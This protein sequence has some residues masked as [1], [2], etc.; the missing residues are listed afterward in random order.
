MER[1]GLKTGSTVSIKRTDGRVHPAV[2][3]G[4][5]DAANT[6]TVEWFENDETKGKELDMKHILANNPDLAARGA[7]LA[8]QPAQQPQPAQPAGQPFAAP[9][10]EP[11]AQPPSQPVAPVISQ[12]QPSAQFAE[13]SAARGRPSVAQP[14]QP[15]SH[16]P[17]AQPTPQPKKL[18]P[19]EPAPPAAS[20]KPKP[21]AQTPTSSKG[22]PSLAVAPGPAQAAGAKKSTLAEVQK[23][24]K[25]R[26]ERR[27]QQQHN[28]VKRDQKGGKD[29]TNI[30]II[31]MIEDYREGVDIR[32]LDP[33]GPVKNQKIT[34][35]VR[36]R[37]LNRRERENFD[38][39]V[40]TIPDGELITVHEP[41]TKVDLTKY[42]D[43]HNFRFD[44]AFD[45]D[46][47]N[48]TVY[49][50]TASPLVHT[51]FQGGMATCFA[52]GQTGSGKTFTMGGDFSDVSSSGVPGIY[53]FA[54]ADVFRLNLLSDHKAKGLSVS[55]S[56]FE[57]YG[58]KVFDLLNK[59]QK[60]RILEDGNG[61]VQIV[62][63]S[64]VPVSSVAEVNE[65]VRLGS[66]ARAQGTTSANQ[67]SSRSHAVFQ[68][69]LRAN[70][71]RKLHGKLSLIDLAGNERGA[72]TA[73]AGRQTRME[74]AEINKS[75]LALK[76]CIRALGRKG[77]HCP[78]RASKL[79]QVL[80]DSFIAENARTCMIAMISP[81]IHS[82][83]NSLNTLRYADRVKE[84]EAAGR[85]D[86][87]QFEALENVS[88]PDSD[89]PSGADLNDSLAKH[90]LELLHHTLRARGEKFDDS[91][92]LFDFQQA[93][94]EA[95]EAEDR[96]QEEHRNVLQAELG[97]IAEEERLLK[98][99]DRE[100]YDVEDYVRRLEEILAA[101]IQK[102]SLLQG[103]VGRLRRQLQQEEQASK[104]VAKLRV[105]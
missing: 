46:V 26:E 40:I 62:G 21:V 1:Y 104:G 41:K 18:Q 89:A 3:S 50:Y 74:G 69:I 103:N 47:D 99:T 55:V 82:C 53:T 10:R 37:P 7:K 63:L 30:D 100:D 61:V 35:C 93:A 14:A 92:K 38:Y 66:L 9:V 95:L 49:R 51:I 56:F 83:E 5:N 80:R 29:N 65:L 81:G 42:I 88:F 34:V 19:P 25:Q 97:F 8:V 70:K 57:L 28:L 68:I 102:L 86:E 31:Q 73:N 67:S 84:L 98:E 45:V 17:L 90:D 72:D 101:K 43:H 20:G 79:T 87:D 22:R 13:P 11:A 64:E 32:S 24:E 16:A 91:E 36:K 4:F 6:V 39:D 94:S 15:K 60:L 59:S 23:I 75:L 105:V 2:V 58:V 44:H 77:A 48:A 71:A 12:A 54:I 78:F 76:E 27:A 52:Y 33:N 85:T 96:L